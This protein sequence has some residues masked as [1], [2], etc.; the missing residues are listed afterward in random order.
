M[1]LF[2]AW[3]SRSTSA[4]QPAP[5]LP[6][7]RFTD[8]DKTERQQQS[9]TRAVDGFERQQYLDAY[10]HFFEY[11]RQPG[12]HNPTYDE[13]RGQLHFRL[14]QGSQRISGLGDARRF[15]ATADLAPLKNLPD[16]L[17]RELLHENYFL[18]HARFAISER[19]QLCLVFDTP[20][21]TASPDKLYRALSELA[22]RADE[23][24]DLLRQG[25]PPD[26]P[27]LPERVVAT[28][29]RHLRTRIERTLD[30]LAAGKLLPDGYP[31]T[32][33]F[34]LM[35][36]C[37]ELDYL[38]RPEGFVRQTFENLHRDYIAYGPQRAAA[39]NALAE[40]ELRKI[41][42]R[43]DAEL[44]GEFYGTRHVFGRTEPVN[45]EFPRNFIRA[46]IGA[47]DWFALNGYPRVP[48]HVAGYL[49]GHLLFRYAP[50]AGLRTQL[51]R[52]FQVLEPDY[53]RELGLEVPFFRANGSADAR[54]LRRT[55]G[56][57]AEPETAGWERR[58]LQLCL[59]GT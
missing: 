15:R 59:E 5:Q 40:T 2:R 50:E 28:R 18:R 29:V 21:A 17:L 6:F 45:R 44:H 12:S 55:F 43:T 1:S 13:R 23:L 19:E 26:A 48:R 54:Q 57:D 10:R 37:Y 39:F 30:E 11:L 8:R 49:A 14:Q 25:P 35:G 24:D 3:F 53:F 33:T 31:G 16:G 20:A 27:A 22:L 41:L 32:R 7:G 34:I 36:L 47:G 56:G 52:F 58:L 51:H 46:Q 9:F 4:A 38:T 42:A